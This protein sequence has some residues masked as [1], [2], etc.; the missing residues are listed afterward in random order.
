MYFLLQSNLHRGKIINSL[1]KTE[2][3]NRFG[4]L[5]FPE[6]WMGLESNMWCQATHEVSPTVMHVCF[7]YW[8]FSE[9]CS[10]K[11]CHQFSVS[12]NE[13][14]CIERFLVRTW[15]C[16]MSDR[17]ALAQRI[18][19][20]LTAC[21]HSL[22]ICCQAWENKESSQGLIR[23]CQGRSPEHRCSDWEWPTLRLGPHSRPLD[24]FTS[25]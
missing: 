13:W 4:E 24:Q 20:V 22:P 8:R 10:S 21:A 18:R 11:R 5:S 25:A 7:W 15:L 23:A 6:L 1:T 19:L 17:W 14:G 3:T 9:L 2:N 16:Q 12:H